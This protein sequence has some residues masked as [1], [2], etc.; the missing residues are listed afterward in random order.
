MLSP[1]LSPS[2]IRGGENP[3]THAYNRVL[4]GGRAPDDAVLGLLVTRP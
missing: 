2:P 1:A 3:Y 4:G